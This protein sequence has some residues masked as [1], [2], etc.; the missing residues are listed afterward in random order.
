[1]LILVADDLLYGICENPVN[2]LVL[3]LVTDKLLYGILENPINSLVFD[4]SHSQT[5]L[6][7]S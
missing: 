3:T 5:P 2:G 6:W 4:T 1:L 7:N